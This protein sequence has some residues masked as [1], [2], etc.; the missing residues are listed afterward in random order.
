MKKLFLIIHNNFFVS[1]HFS[2]YEILKRAIEQPEPKKAIG[3]K[4]YM[5]RNF[6]NSLAAIFVLEAFNSVD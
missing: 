3:S 2:I 4:N 1:G 5:W 6:E